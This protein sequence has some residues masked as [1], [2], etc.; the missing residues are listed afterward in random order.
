MR[1]LFW[2]LAVFAG[3][4]ALALAGRVGEGYLLVVYPP[5]RV[6]VS[7]LLA[8]IGLLVG[9][10]L[11]YL[12]LRLLGHT[13]ALPDYVR[14]FRLRR[15]RERAQGAHEAALQAF[16]EGRYARAEKEAGIAWETGDSPGLAALLAAR[17]AHQLRQHGR[18]DE[19]LE[20]AGAAG[21]SLHVAGLLTR[22]EL[23]LDERDFVGARDALRSLHGAGPR[24][25]AAARMLLRAERGAQ[26]WE[27]VLRLATM[28]AKRDAIP[29]AIAQEHRVQAHIE[30][31]ARDA[32]ERGTLEARMRRIPSEDLTHPRVASAA[33]RHCAALG[34]L[35]RAREL[36]ERA[37]G[38]EWNASLLQLY[39][40]PGG[41][42]GEARAAEVRTRIERAERWLRERAEDPQLLIAL[43]R[44]CAAAEL[45][46][47]ARD[48]LEASLSFEQT[49]IAHL[50]LARLAERDARAA[51][52]QKHFRRAV[53]L[54]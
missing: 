29:M 23:A 31:M 25:I 51:E 3:A 24:N 42:E 4:V 7:L 9:F 21:E 36:I 34:E 20:R 17:A 27:E 41:P 43:G 47:K 12:L 48:Y 19:W 37:L 22:A 16:F 18:R 44:L 52:A 26:N 11:A 38:A 10:G 35:A 45:W 6:E 53:E 5:W 39:A 50:E 2:L 28:L 49:R 54:S 13:F 14:A 15:R 40:E 8:L 46:G 33:A 32:G 30:L 1:A